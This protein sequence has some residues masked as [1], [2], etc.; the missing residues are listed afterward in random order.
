[1]VATF[2]FTVRL[3]V[4]AGD[5]VTVN[6]ADVPSV[7][8]AL[9]GAMEISGGVAA[10]AVGQV[11]V[12]ATNARLSFWPMVQVSPE[13]LRV[14]ESVPLLFGV[15]GQGFQVCDVPSKHHVKLPWGGVAPDP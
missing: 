14:V 6:V 15:A 8:A 11:S 7:T 10:T 12:D 9:P 5:A 4:G 13:L 1:M 3:D 2:R